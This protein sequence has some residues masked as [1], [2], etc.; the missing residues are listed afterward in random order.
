MV[1][2]LKIG[3]SLLLNFEKTTIKEFLEK[4]KEKQFKVIEIVLEPPYCDVDQID[5]IKRESIKQLAKQFGI[6]ITIHATF[7]DINIAAINKSVRKFAVSEIFKC[8]DFAKD[9]GSN[10]VTIHPGIYGALGFTYPHLTR[11]YQIESLKEICLYAQKS[12]III[13][14]ENMP[15]M[16]NDQPEEIYD[17]FLIKE[18]IDEVNCINL[19]FT[20]DVGHTHTTEFSLSDFS[21]ALGSKIGHIHLHDNLGPKDGWSDTHLELGKGSINWQE[22]FSLLDEVSYNGTG[23]FELNTWNKIDNSMNYLSKK[24][25]L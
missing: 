4:S 17:P 1:I 11:K 6:L 15:L 22:F 24:I 8:I 3:T 25:D 5:N 10:Y 2:Y 7:S 19:K 16:P 23:V 21:K 18:L 9:V 12:N 20:W 13:G 14:F